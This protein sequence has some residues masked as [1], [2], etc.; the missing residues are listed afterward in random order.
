L[1]EIFERAGFIAWPLL[2]ASVSGVA[3][4]LERL[5]STQRER[6]LP[7]NLDLQVSE[8][9]RAAKL[10]EAIAVCRRDDSPLAR[11]LVA[12]L[13]KIRSQRDGVSREELIEVLELTG[14]RELSA[15]QRYVGILGTIAAI[16][17]LLGLLGTV[18]GM[19]RTFA[20][21]E[22]N[23]I[24]NPQLLAGGIS[25]ALTATAAGICIA[26][27]AVVF[28]RLFLSRAR[29]LGLELEEAVHAILF[30]FAQRGA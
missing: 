14:K 7:R 29:A 26:V 27:P 2:I 4:I 18:L 13:R 30:E 25:E 15:L 3:V 21:I 19:I 28:Y 6:V 8:L 20:V 1:L 17:P 24:G 10:E 16:A 23:G 11:I 5:W 22:V 9:V 12:G